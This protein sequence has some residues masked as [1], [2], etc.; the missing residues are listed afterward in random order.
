[1]VDV[2]VTGTNWPCVLAN[3]PIYIYI[4]IV[5]RQLVAEP[6]YE[7]IALLRNTTELLV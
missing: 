1:M 2:I 7:A 6:T 3:L 5:P 4:Y